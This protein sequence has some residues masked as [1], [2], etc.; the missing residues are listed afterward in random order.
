LKKL[1]QELQADLEKRGRALMRALE[2]SNAARRG[3]LW[4][5]SAIL[6]LADQ[7]L[8]TPALARDIM[9]K[10]GLGDA[11]DVVG[12]RRA[13][14]GG[15]LL[16]NAVNVRECAEL[17]GGDR[18]PGARGEV[19]DLGEV[20]QDLADVGVQG[21]QDRRGGVVRTGGSSNDPAQILGLS[22]ARDLVA[23]GTSAGALSAAPAVAAQTVSYADVAGRKRREIGLPRE[24]RH[25][26]SAKADDESAPVFFFLLHSCDFLQVG[27]FVRLGEIL[28]LS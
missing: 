28:R 1:V 12:T 13:P 6:T 23:S 9:E 16:E 7:N 18:P 11:L 27:V 5:F 20:G 15:R 4:V 21:H 2:D 8:L 24:E 19:G 10:A 14:E 26:D 3:S 25:E 22:R 17:R